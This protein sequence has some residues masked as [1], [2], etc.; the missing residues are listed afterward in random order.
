[1]IFGRALL[2]EFAQSASGVF[3][4][5]VAI[6]LTTQFIRYLGQAASGSLAVDAVLA[7]LGFSALS[8]FPVLLSLTLFISVLMPLTRSY[9]DSEMIVWFTS[10]ISLLAWIRPVLIFA[11]P[12][13]VTIGLLSLFLSPWSVRLAEEYRA[14]LNSRDEVSGVAPGVFRESRRAERVF[15]VEN[16]EGEANQVG[17]VF[18]RSIQHQREGIMVAKRGY[19]E[20]APN[21]D[22]FLVLLNGSRYEGPPGSAEFR[23]TRFERYAMRI[24]AYEAKRGLPTVKSLDTDVLFRLQTRQAHG[25]LAWRIGQPVSAFIL[26]LLAIPLAFVNPRGGRSL[27]LVLALLVYVFYS[28][29]MSVVQAWVVQGRVGALTGVLGL[30]VFMLLVLAVLL[31]WRIGAFSLRRKF[32]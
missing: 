17:N 5:L 11:L 30:H 29:C 15:F 28:N 2:R 19:Q 13:V 1:M 31:Y 20:T 22:R 26:T 14:Q 24:E 25:E 32:R 6:T 21:G 23:V 3:L 12:L 7:M 18:V 8:H 27:N 4:V 10:G 9:R 16:I